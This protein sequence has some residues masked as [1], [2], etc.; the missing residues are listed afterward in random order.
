MPGIGL[1]SWTRADMKC[2]AQCPVTR[3]RMVLYDLV[4]EERDKQPVQLICPLL[5]AEGV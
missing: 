1:A 5:S 3:Q 4:S 2:P